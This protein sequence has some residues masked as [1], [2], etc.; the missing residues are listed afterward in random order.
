[1]NITYHMIYEYDDDYLVWYCNFKDS[2]NFDFF[3][4]M[5]SSF[6][7]IVCT[8]KHLVLRITYMIYIVVRSPGAR[9][10]FEHNATTCKIL[11]N[12]LRY[13]CGVLCSQ[14]IAKRLLH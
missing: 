6:N 14:D 12:T 2:S 7:P 8:V 13:N 3:L 4:D 9:L 5:A 10:C 1:M 11:F